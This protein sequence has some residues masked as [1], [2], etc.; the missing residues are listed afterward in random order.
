V[1]AK[2]RGYARRSLTEFDEVLTD[3]HFS[4]HVDDDRLAFTISQDGFPMGL[5]TALS[6]CEHIL[7]NCKPANLRLIGPLKFWFVAIQE[8]AGARPLYRKV[9]VISV[10]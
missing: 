6:L 3:A 5:F 1:L 8:N 2:T 4:F 9:L 10:K 7:E